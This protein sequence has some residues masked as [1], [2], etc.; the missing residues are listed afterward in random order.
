[1]FIHE[2]RR[3][4]Q[5]ALTKWLVMGDFNL[6]YR[7]QD[8]S[9]N[10]LNRRLMLKFRRALNHMEI[11]EIQLTSRQFTWSNSQSTPTLSRI[12]RMFCSPEWEQ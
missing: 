4:K 11:K 10:R 7:E 8:K 6:I 2:L 12:D 1:M 9:N 5:S 3:L